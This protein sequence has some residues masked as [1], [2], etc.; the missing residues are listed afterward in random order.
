MVVLLLVAKRQ[1]SIHFTGFDMTIQQ[2]DRIQFS[3]DMFEASFADTDRIPFRGNVNKDDNLGKGDAG[4][5]LS[6]TNTEELHNF[7]WLPFL[8]KRK[9][10][11]H[12]TCTAQ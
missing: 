10:T 2:E 12:P 5:C 9:N 11:S 1:Y 8:V 3:R 7:P 4:Q 6:V